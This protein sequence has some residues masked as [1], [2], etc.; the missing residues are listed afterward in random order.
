MCG[1]LSVGQSGV[2]FMKTLLL[3]ACPF[4]KC[5]CNMWDTSA[6]FP[7]RDCV[8]GYVKSWQYL[9]FVLMKHGILMKL[10]VLLVN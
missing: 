2:V 7:P 9:L 10:Q 3:E 1:V 5:V 4:L 8:N 6:S